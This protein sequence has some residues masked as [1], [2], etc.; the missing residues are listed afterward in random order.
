LVVAFTDMRL[1]ILPSDDAGLRHV[2][3]VV[4]GGGLIVYPTETLY[5]IGCDP[6]NGSAVARVQELKGRG[7]KAF[8]VLVSSLAE[9]RKLVAVG[10]AA[11]LLMEAFWPGALTLVLRA[12][13]NASRL[14]EGTGKVGVRM[15]RQELA[16]KVIEV[17]GGALVGTSANL[18]GRPPART[19]DELDP[20]I[21]GGVDL[22]VDGGPAELGVASTVLDVLEGR[23][24]ISAELKVL[25]E[26]ALEIDAIKR[27]IPLWREEG[28][29][30]E[31]V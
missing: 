31:I 20:R 5:G 23:G 12:K 8:P 24:K 4:K 1:K 9:A 10:K 21:E 18:S 11:R 15:P 13:P 2:A 7:G 19:V 14:G 27:R 6:S 29:E 28:I 3:R 25:R 30:V 26:G 17:C 22:V 16:L